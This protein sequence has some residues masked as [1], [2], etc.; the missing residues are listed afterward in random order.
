MP[1]ITKTSTSPHALNPQRKMTLHG[2]TDCPRCGVDIG[3]V[4]SEPDDLLHC[5]ECKGALLN[6]GRM[7]DGGKDRAAD[8]HAFSW[9]APADGLAA[10]E[11]CDCGGCEVARE[12]VEGSR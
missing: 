2:N 4:Y 5:P 1:H 9:F 6:C 3:R 11:P 8:I 12:K 10:D 7:E